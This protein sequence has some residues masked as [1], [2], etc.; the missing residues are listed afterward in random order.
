[1]REGMIKAVETQTNL[2]ELA[3]FVVARARLSGA[4]D[5]T[6]RVRS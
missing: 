3:E 4:T 1:L 5:A 2:Q 6:R